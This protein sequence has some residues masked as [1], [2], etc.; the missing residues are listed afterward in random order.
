MT[1]RTKLCSSAGLQHALQV[2]RFLI[3]SENDTGVETE[4]TG[5]H[6]SVELGVNYQ[7]TGAQTDGL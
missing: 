4:D 7:D 1:G 2:S 5:R 6:S 3:K